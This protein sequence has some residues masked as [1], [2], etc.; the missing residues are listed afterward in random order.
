M[1]NTYD[2]VLELAKQWGL[3]MD[4]YPHTYKL[5]FKAAMESKDVPGLICEI[6][7]RMG[8]GIFTMMCAAGNSK[9]YIGIDPY[10]QLPIPTIP[11]IHTDYT[12]GMKNKFLKNIY[13]FCEQSDINF[14]HFSMESS[15]FINRFAD[16]VPT[17]YSEKKTL[18][19]SYAVV[20]VDGV[21]STDA[22]LTETKFFVERLS[23]N[24]FISYD[25]WDVYDN[26]PID[27]YLSPRGINKVDTISHKNL[28]KFGE[29]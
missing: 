13:A 11:G 29:V 21:H 18:E 19:S 5:L 4:G 2:D 12:N 1:V 10:G 16:G 6:G 20:H 14:T 3:E 26:G 7:V 24:G 23:P 17:Y 25:N 8:F 27:E 22:V 15:E 9:A 28:Y